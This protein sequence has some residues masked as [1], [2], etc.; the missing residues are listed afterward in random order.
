MDDVSLWIAAT[1]TLGGSRKWLTPNRRSHRLEALPKPHA[2]TGTPS[3]HPQSSAIEM[4]YHGAGGDPRG[5]YATSWG[6]ASSWGGSE[7]LGQILKDRVGRLYF[8]RVL[9]TRL[10]RFPL[11]A[12]ARRPELL[13]SADTP[14][15]PHHDVISYSED[16]NIGIVI[17]ECPP[18]PL[19]HLLASAQWR[20]RAELRRV[21]ERMHDL[22]SHLVVLEEHGISLNGKA[23]S[24]GW[25]GSFRTSGAG[26]WFV[27]AY[28][29]PAAKSFHPG[30]LAR[31]ALFEERLPEPPSNAWPVAPLEGE[32]G[33]AGLPWSQLTAYS[34]PRVKGPTTVRRH[35][36][37][38]EPS[39]A[40]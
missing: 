4:L 40:S 7:G 30:R 26:L 14:F 20:E 17:T 28:L 9:D 3:E 27:P 21:L 35:A 15:L 2:R 38:L 33:I 31:S 11:E 36:A 37:A 19:S 32:R 6:S 22:F 18:Y 24:E 34:D 25:V 5:V 10:Q 13:Y 23:P 1:S 8:A 12:A 39:P 29:E 16:S